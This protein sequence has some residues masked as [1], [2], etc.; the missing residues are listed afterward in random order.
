MTEVFDCVFF[1]SGHAFT[2]LAV[3]RN[4]FHVVK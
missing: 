1:I 2:A 4:H 3:A